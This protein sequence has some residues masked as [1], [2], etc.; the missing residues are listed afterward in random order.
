M[1]DL[2]ARFHKIVATTGRLRH[3]FDDHGDRAYNPTGWLH[4]VHGALRTLR[5]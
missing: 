2:L 5:R 4:V 1:L 3:E